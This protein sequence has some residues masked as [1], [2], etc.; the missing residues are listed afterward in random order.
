MAAKEDYYSLLGVERTASVEEIKKAYRKQAMKYHPD[1][2]PGDTAAEARFKE[3]SEAYEVLSDPAK[4]G[5]YD[6]FGHEGLK[7]TFGPGGFDFSRDFTHA[8]DL[9]DIL[10]NLFG[11]GGGIFDEFFG[12]SSRRRSSSHAG[13]R[14]SDLRF[15]LEIDLEEAIFGSKREVKLPASENCDDCKGSGVARGSRRES[16][17][18]CGG[19][20][21]VVSG[22]GFFQ[23]RQTCPICNGSGSI[24][25]NPCKTCGGAG[26][27]RARRNLT[28]T[29][30]PGVDT[31][32]RLRLSG[33]GESGI[34]NGPP[35]DLYV[36]LHLRAHPL[37]ERQG[38]DLLCT[39]H[40]PFDVAALG[41]N[42]DV[43]TIDGYARLKLAAGTPSGKVFRLRNKGV[44]ASDG[45][46]RGDLHVRVV[47]ESPSKLSG[48]QKKIIK[49]AGEAIGR[50]CYPQIVKQ[51]Q[52]AEEF[53][54]RR[55]ALK[56]N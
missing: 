36:V 12:G 16:C 19:Q 18:Q 52:Q 11:Q 20:G 46:G 31:G 55:D 33:K 41:G 49:Q 26:R 2:N 37:F 17:R 27:V 44:P 8:S 15:D 54:T 14:G 29:I 9:Q 35:G 1:R 40:A 23:I 7:S 53:F 38:D 32:T 22:G 13:Q 30:P 50:N 56:K 21:Q 51:Q 48:S 3:L 6:Q 43:P 47:T 42:I 28:L 34:R 5:K 39:V 45:Y 4:R 25:R 10:G 24:I